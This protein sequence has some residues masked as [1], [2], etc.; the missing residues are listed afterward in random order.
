MTL[1]CG[2]VTF[3]IKNEDQKVVLQCISIDDMGFIMRPPIGEFVNQSFFRKT[4]V[5]SEGV[6]YKIKSIDFRQNIIWLEIV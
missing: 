2:A 3:S 4:L 5:D 6:E 1:I